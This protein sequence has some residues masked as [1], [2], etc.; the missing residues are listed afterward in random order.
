ML[1]APLI[2]P[3]ITF[4]SLVLNNPLCFIPFWLNLLNPAYIAGVFENLF[5]FLATGIW[6]IF[7]GLIGFIALP[8]QAKKEEKILR[9]LFDESYEDNESKT[10]RFFPKIWNNNKKE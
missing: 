7:F 9:E 10:G 6:A 8:Y 5:I 1:A 4:P 3:W 2:S